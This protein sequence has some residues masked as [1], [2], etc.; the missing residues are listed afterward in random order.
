MM[1]WVDFLVAEVMWC[2]QLFVGVCG[3]KS[4]LKTHSRS[5]ILTNLSVTESIG[6][7]MLAK[8]I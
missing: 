3:R 4:I 1:C 5:S 6:M 2:D 8:E 7:E